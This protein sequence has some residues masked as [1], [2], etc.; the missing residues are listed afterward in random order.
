MNLA[1]I[2]EEQGRYEDA[3]AFYVKTLEGRQRVLGGE[4]RET[5][6]SM[7]KLASLY[8]KRDRYDEAKALLNKALEIGRRVFGIDDVQTQT[9]MTSAMIRKDFKDARYR[10]AR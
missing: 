7:T 6:D 4:H 3:E 8:C 9:S 2:Y 5:L 10:L 1:S